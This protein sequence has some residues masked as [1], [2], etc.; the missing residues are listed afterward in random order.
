MELDQMQNYVSAA[1]ERLNLDKDLTFK[2]MFGGGMA[3]IGG[4]PAASLS[5]IGIA[6]KLAPLDQEELLAID[7]AA[8]LQYEPDAPVSK[9]YIVVPKAMVSNPALLAP[10]L[11]RSSDYILSLPGK[12]PKAKPIK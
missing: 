12:K 11:K 4:K 5:N 10:W 9:S 6:L 8:R 7:G 2:K 1:A 3:Y